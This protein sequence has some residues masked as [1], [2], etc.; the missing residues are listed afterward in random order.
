MWLSIH[1]V[2]EKLNLSIDTIRR[3][4][5]KGLI[6]AERSNKNHRMFNDDEV[7]ALLNKLNNKSEEEFK[8]LKSEIK[9]PYTAIELFAGA[10]GTALGFENAGIQHILLNEIDKDCV[11]TLKHNFPKGTNIIH[12]DVHNVDFSS[13]KG[14]VDIVQA[15]F[16]CQAFSYAGK[17]MGFED[18]R[19][20]LFFEFARCV[21]ETMPKIAVG[22]NVKGLLKHDNGRTLKTMVNALKEIGYNVQ[23]KVLR[24]QYLDVPQKRERL[25]II[26]IRND[27]HI[28]FIFP[29]EKN[30]TVSL[31]AALKDCPKSEGQSYPKRKAEILS[32][33]P[34]GGYWRDLPIDI[35]KEYMKGSFLLSGG[36]T[37]MARRLSWDEPSLTLTC[38]PA[39]KQTERCHPSETRPLTIREYARIQSFP[40]NWK[41]QGTISS[42]YKQIGNAVP[43][44]LSY[45][46]GCCLI[47]MLDGLSACS[48]EEQFFKM[49]AE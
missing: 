32:L 39:Q 48:L 1:E 33:V 13:W 8:V 31:R 36:K 42:Q 43:V 27:L 49:A 34:E 18:T 6:K 40:D 23:Y 37:G 25:I 16:P 12:V 7:F 5:K 26:A 38:A 10:G 22:E 9:S 17:S 28:P 20:T 4:E 35:Q 46:I 14:K 24:A 2:S 30:Y 45:H 21:K 11:A 44:N 15:G 41:F 19:G 47:E 29:T 3:W